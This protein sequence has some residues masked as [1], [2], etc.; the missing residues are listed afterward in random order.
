MGGIS[1]G[2]APLSA[3]MPSRPGG[4]K[5][6]MSMDFGDDDELSMSDLGDDLEM[7]GDDDDGG[8]SEADL[9][10]LAQFKGSID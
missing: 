5:D 1:R 7:E 2:G 3:S 9:A 6:P 8:L 10:L 4:L